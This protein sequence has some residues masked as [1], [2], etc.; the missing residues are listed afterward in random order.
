MLAVRRLVSLTYRWVWG[1][2]IGLGIPFIVAVVIDEIWFSTSEASDI[3]LVLLAAVGGAFTGVLQAPT[4]RPYTPLAQWWVLASII[5]WG[6][7]W[8][9]SALLGEGGFLLGGIILGA[10]SGSLLIWILKF[11]SDDKAV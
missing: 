10:V 6:L 1:A 2:A 4:L 8:L 11:S 9:I 5:A 3:W 7:A